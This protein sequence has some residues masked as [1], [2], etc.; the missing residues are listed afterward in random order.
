MIPVSLAGQQ[1][2]GPQSHFELYLFSHKTLSNPL[3][4][5]LIWQD[6]SP[7][8]P[9]KLWQK[10]NVDIQQDVEHV[11]LLHGGDS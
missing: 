9:K 3:L 5:W 7:T 11:H 8:V 2:A 1:R 6:G 4:G 10:V